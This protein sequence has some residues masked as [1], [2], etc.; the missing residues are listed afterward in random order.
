MWVAQGPF[1]PFPATN[2]TRWFSSRDLYPSAWISEWWAK[3]SLPP[4]SGVMKPKPFSLLNHFTIPI[5]FFNADPKYKHGKNL[6]KSIWQLYLIKDSI[7]TNE[8]CHQNNAKGVFLSFAMIKTIHI[9][10]THQQKTQWHTCLP[11]DF[12]HTKTRLLVQYVV[13]FHQLE[14]KL[15]GFC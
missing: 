11:I 10:P 14:D 3:R 5:S 15:Y 12:S 4:S 6:P 2:E 8:K 13:L 1:W 7:I 9:K